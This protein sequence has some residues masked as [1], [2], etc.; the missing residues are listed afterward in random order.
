MMLRDAGWL[1][2]NVADGYVAV[3]EY[4]ATHAPV[5]AM[6]VA[7]FQC[8]PDLTAERMGKQLDFLVFHGVGD[9]LTAAQIARVCDRALVDWRAREGQDGARDE[10]RGIDVGGE[11]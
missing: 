3:D 11:S 10:D 9:G 4:K 1:L 5:F 2:G 8:N 6:A 7:R